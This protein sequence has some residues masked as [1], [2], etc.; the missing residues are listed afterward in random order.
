MKS[1]LSGLE[2]ELRQLVRG[3][4]SFTPAERAEVEQF[5]GAGEYGV[6]FETICGVVKEE[7]RPVPD[8]LR[9]VIRQLAQRMEI[10][11]DWWS[12]IV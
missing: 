3:I 11:P 9:P 4:A 5:L 6:A 12:E 10:D 8:G 1:D 7:G 2:D